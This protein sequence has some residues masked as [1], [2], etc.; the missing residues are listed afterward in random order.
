MRCPF[1]GKDWRYQV[2]TG[3]LHFRENS[4][5]WKSSAISRKR[6]DRAQCHQRWAA[7]SEGGEGSPRAEHRAVFWAEK[8][9]WERS[10]DE[11]CSSKWDWSDH[12]AEGC[13]SE[14][15][16]GLEERGHRF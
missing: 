13:L 3:E 5:T 12:G 4:S 2:R 16:G 6:R 9:I 15:G 1:C 10:W 11:G 8:R 14:G 7:P